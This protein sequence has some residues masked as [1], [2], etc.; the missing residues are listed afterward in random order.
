MVIV[1]RVVVRKFVGLALAKNI[2]KVMVLR[3][4]LITE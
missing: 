4:N 1:C 3:G 2:K